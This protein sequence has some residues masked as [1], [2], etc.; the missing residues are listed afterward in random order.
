MSDFLFIYCTIEKGFTSNNKFRLFCNQGF[1]GSYVR[2]K[3]VF[4]DFQHI[5]NQLIFFQSWYNHESHL[6]NK[7][8]SLWAKVF[9]LS[10]IKWWYN[11][12]LTPYLSSTTNCLYPE[13]M[14]EKAPSFLSLRNQRMSVTFYQAVIE[15]WHTPLL[16]K[17]IQA[18]RLN[19]MLWFLFCI[20]TCANELDL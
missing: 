11:L 4:N 10:D 19:V 9:I 5:E 13:Y 14:Y 3:K 16:N 20:P 18:V 2:Q 7:L 15:S 6:S 12:L 1:I 8:F 17:R